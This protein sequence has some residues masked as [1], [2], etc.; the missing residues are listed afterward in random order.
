[1]SLGTNPAAISTQQT[2]P[3]H[4]AWRATSVWQTAYALTRAR[5]T[6]V[7]AST[8]PAVQTNQAFAPVCQKGLRTSSVQ[9]LYGTARLNCGIAVARMPT[10]QRHVILL[11]TSGSLHQRQ[12]CCKLSSP[13]HQMGGPLQVLPL[14]QQRLQLR[15][16][17]SPP[18]IPAC[19]HRPVA[20]RP[21]QKLALVLV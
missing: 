2:L 18:Q 3:Y 1:M 19:H 13:I 17:R 12:R 7:M 9:T 20:S 11:R 14:S 21:A 16:P 6:A 4:A 8:L 10:T 5:R 15:P